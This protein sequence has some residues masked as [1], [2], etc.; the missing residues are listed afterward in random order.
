MARTSAVW[1]RE[2]TSKVSIPPS[3]HALGYRRSGACAG[4]E[5]RF[6]EPP[7][8]LK[9]Q[10]Q[11]PRQSRCLANCDVTTRTDPP[12]HVRR[13]NKHGSSQSTHVLVNRS[14]LPDGGVWQC[15]FDGSE[16][17]MEAA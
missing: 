11:D 15:L 9:W 4:L 13:D 7:S 17:R 14:L 16:V 5:Q 12:N 10:T 3:R 8:D 6:S 2:S 1:R